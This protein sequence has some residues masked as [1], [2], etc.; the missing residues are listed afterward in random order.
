MF[1]LSLVPVKHTSWQ[2][3]FEAHNLCNTFIAWWSPHTIVMCIWRLWSLINEI[4]LTRK[5]VFKKCVRSDIYI[6]GM[7]YHPLH[8][9][10]HP[11]IAAPRRL[12]FHFTTLRPMIYM[13]IFSKFG[14]PLSQ[15]GASHWHCERKSR[16]TESFIITKDI[17]NLRYIFV[18]LFKHDHPRCK[19][20]QSF[21]IRLV[22]WTLLKPAPRIAVTSESPVLEWAFSWQKLICTGCILLRSDVSL[23]LYSLAQTPSM[24]TRAAST[25]N[26]SAFASWGGLSSSRRFALRLRVKVVPRTR[27]FRTSFCN[28]W[29]TI[30]RRSPGALRLFALVVNVGY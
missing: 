30:T 14:P 15:T 20:Q 9:L 19:Y 22:K 6:F 11:H 10:P 13:S 5:F 21:R 27:A 4:V 23:F 12:W 26:P 25:N 24:I 17:Q 7:F 18:L 16:T 1:S 3:P 29:P 28:S 2:N 8:P